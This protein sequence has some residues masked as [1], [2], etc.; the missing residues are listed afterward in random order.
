MDDL[1][2]ARHGLAKTG[3]EPLVL[4][5]GDDAAGLLRQR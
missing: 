2:V 1:D 4:L 5:Y 3:D